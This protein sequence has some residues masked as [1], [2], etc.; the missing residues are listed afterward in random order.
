MIDSNLLYQVSFVTKEN[1]LLS[2]VTNSL[3]QR[4]ETVPR[5]HRELS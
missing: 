2:V 1:S 3:P 5:H 4:I